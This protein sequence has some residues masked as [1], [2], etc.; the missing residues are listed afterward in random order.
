MFYCS[1]QAAAAS[2]PETANPLVKTVVE[3]LGGAVRSIDAV[4]SRVTCNP[5]PTSTD[6]DWLI[7]LRPPR[8]GEPDA[9]ALLVELGFRQD[10]SPEFYTGNDRGGFFS[11][12][13]DDL[14]LITTYDPQFYDLFMT[15]TALAKR[16]NL[17]GKA[18]RIA[19]FQGVLYQ[20]RAP[21][22]ETS[23]PAVSGDPFQS[24]RLA[25]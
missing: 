11:W 23:A 3:H 20:V 12:R 6:E 14:N 4:G 15:A 22:L 2:I 9:I 19:L 8:K 10:G 17:L 1:I 18:D 25:S 13:Q 5:A 16:F 7:L 24:E 21:Q